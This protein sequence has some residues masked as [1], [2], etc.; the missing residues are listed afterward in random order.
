MTEL[1]KKQPEEIRRD[2]R[3]LYAKAFE[4]GEDGNWEEDV[5]A[6]LKLM[7]MEKM[8]KTEEV[9]HPKE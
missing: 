9:E 8:K 7:G 2:V 4:K 5:Y 3:R 6:A 1:Y